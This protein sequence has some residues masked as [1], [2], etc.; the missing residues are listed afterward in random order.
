MDNISNELCNDDKLEVAGTANIIKKIRA[1]H[2][3]FEVKDIY[4]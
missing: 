3:D 1:L 4:E 2:P